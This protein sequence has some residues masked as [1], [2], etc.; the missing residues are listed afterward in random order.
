MNDHLLMLNLLSVANLFEDLDVFF[1]YLGFL[2]DVSWGKL[3]R[4]LG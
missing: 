2:K 4:V 1:H 3:V